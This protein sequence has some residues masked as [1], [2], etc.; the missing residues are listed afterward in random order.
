MCAQRLE[1]GADD[2]CLDSTYP[3]E[4]FLPRACTHAFS[5]LIV[6]LLGHEGYQDNL[7][8]FVHPAA[9]IALVG[10][11]TSEWCAG[12]DRI[13]DRGRWKLA[14]QKPEMGNGKSSCGMH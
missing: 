5:A 7:K 10:A 14:L 13:S 11:A 9:Q 3:C 8:G 6:S 12:A 4:R 2:F 1:H